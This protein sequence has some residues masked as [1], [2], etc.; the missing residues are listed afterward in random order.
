MTIQYGMAKSPVWFHYRSSNPGLHTIVLF[1]VMVDW[2]LAGIHPSILK[3]E[4]G[5][6][7]EGGVLLPVTAGK[8]DWPTLAFIGF[9]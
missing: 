9:L 4:L 5:E 6:T 2:S 3:V 8:L 1:H 7:I